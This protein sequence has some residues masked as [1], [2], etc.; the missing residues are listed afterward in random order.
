MPD[1]TE[2]TEAELKKEL[3]RR[4]KAPLWQRQP[5]WW[6]LFD[7]ISDYCAAW[8]LILISPIWF[9]FWF[10]YK[11]HKG[12]EKIRQEIKDKV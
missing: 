11:I 12:N 7:W 3:K 4:Q 5:L 9:P 1:I 10:A 6:K 8:S 2:F